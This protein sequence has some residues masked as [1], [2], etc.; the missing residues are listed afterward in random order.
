MIMALE[1][2]NPGQFRQTGGDMGGEPAPARKYALPKRPEKP[3]AKPEPQKPVD[4]GAFGSKGY[5]E[6]SRAVWGLRQRRDFYGDPGIRMTEKERMELGELLPKGK[7]TVNERDIKML[8]K[9]LQKKEYSARSTADKFKIKR[10]R[11]AL[12]KFFGTGK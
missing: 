11:E 8:D 4:K 7:G 12:R 10:Q 3:E 2:R 5:V 6:R 1:N 9:E